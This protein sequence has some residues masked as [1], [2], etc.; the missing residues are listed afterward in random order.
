[1]SATRRTG[2]RPRPRGRA[3]SPWTAPRGRSP[4]TT[5]RTSTCC[6]RWTGRTCAASGRSPRRR[7][8]RPRRGCCASSIPPARARPISTSPIR[9][10]A[11]RKG[12]R[13]C[14]TRSRPRAVGSSLSS[15]VEA[16]AGRRVR[17]AQRIGGGDINEAFKGEFQDESVGFGKTRGDVAPGEDV[18]E[19]AGPR[20]LPGPGGG[21]AAGLRWLAEPGGLRLPEVLG[22]SDTVLVLDWVDEG[23]RGDPA[24]FGAGLAE[25]HAAGADDWGAMPGAEA[26]ALRLGSLELPNRP[27]P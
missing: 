4:S 7:R 23:A 6:S 9:I 3:G 24:A 26:A 16:A 11:G 22:V 5:S 17:S 14:S 8:R 25:I 27:A 12:S 2:A 19:G 20:W 15:A 21:E 18:R 10:T 1:M 13:P